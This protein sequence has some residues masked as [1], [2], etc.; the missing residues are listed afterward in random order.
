MSETE[1]VDALVIGTGF[2][3]SVMAYRL[4]EAGLK[5]R[6]LERGKRY[7]PGSFARDPWEMAG[8]FW[9][10]SQGRHG[11][12]QVW[13]FGGID[14]LVSAGVGGGSLIYANVLLRKDE[15]W[16][17][18]RSPDGT[19]VDWP[20]TRADL[21]PHYD[22]VEKI[23]APQR[24][25][26]DI[27]PYRDTPKTR[28]L[29]EAAQ[30]AGLE[31]LLP[32][33]AVTFGDPAEDPIPGEP[34]HDA[35]GGTRDNLH[36]RTRYTCRLT[37]E[38][39]LGCNFGS[40]NSLDYNYLTQAVKAGAD[41]RDRCEVKAMAPRQEGGYAVDYVV[42]DPA[43]EGHPTDTRRLAT[44]RVTADRLVLSA[45]TFGTAYLLLKNRLNFPGISGRLG[46]WFSGNGDMLG[47]VH[48]AHQQ[49][50]GSA[51][52][53]PL[54][55]SRGPVITSTI[56]VPDRRDGGDGPGFYLQEGGYPGLVD[57]MAEATNADGAL[58]RALR[59]VDDRVLAR[60]HHNPQTDL[61]AQIESL[62]GD[63]HRSASMLPL[64]AMGM[65]TPDGTLTMDLR[66]YLALDWTSQHSAEYFA[67]AQGAMES[68]AEALDA[69]L[70]INP[71][72][73]LR[74]KVITVHPVGGCSMGTNP[75]EGV[76][77]PQG[78]VFGYPGMVIADGSV[79]PGPVGPNPSLTIAAVSDRFADHLL[80]A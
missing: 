57:W 55:P 69:K 44:V 38:C 11:L 60:L 26:F 17:I 35:S 10:P 18:R 16:F 77:S 71:L 54:A 52:T 50:D 21:D 37:G 12:F 73:Y 61:D 23:M 14:G 58:H 80:G 4:A 15:H 53:R 6:V 24:Y 72:W 48:D 13:S 9:D 76:V 41:L 47:L 28:A 22:R 59:F 51:A 46:H 62:I 43:Q 67:R 32:P 64:L 42:H 74:H 79:M 40:K 75:A 68:V 36:G 33:L 3:G 70:Q 39:D 19:E 66:G 65:D 30:K 63:A 31:W 78:E 56:R 27:A 2:G 34:I 49:V 7:P 20:L 1:H 45:G 25:P 8:N 5:V 29:Q